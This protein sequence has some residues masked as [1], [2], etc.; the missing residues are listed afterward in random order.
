MCNICFDNTEAMVSL[1]CCA[2]TNVTHDMCHNCFVST[3][4]ASGKCPYC[5][6][7]YDLLDIEGIAEIHGIRLPH[8][9]TEDVINDVLERV[10]V[11]EVLSVELYEEFSDVVD[12]EEVFVVVKD[13]IRR[14]HVHLHVQPKDSDWTRQ[15]IRT[16]AV[17]SVEL[18]QM[19]SQH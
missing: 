4:V 5:R 15:Q 7:V 16:M 11:G 6:K 10:D 14:M 3:V 2:D 17:F 8:K 19:I 13:Y 12:W 9:Y 18:G 1:Q